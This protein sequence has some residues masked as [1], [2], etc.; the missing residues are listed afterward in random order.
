MILHVPGLTS[1]VA[2][3]VRALGTAPTCHSP[4]PLHTMS[5]VLSLMLC[6]S[7]T[8]R[9]RQL[10][11]PHLVLVEEAGVFGKGGLFSFIL[12]DV[13]VVPVVIR[14]YPSLHRLHVLIH[15]LQAGAGVGGPRPGV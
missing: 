8:W 5:A 10:L 11:V 2:W 7:L 9:R 15:A 3:A 4:F 6:P 14:T 1:L 13:A 12:E